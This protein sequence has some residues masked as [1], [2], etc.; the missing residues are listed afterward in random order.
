MCLDKQ[1]PSVKVQPVRTA[2]VTLHTIKHFKYLTLA[3]NIVTRF[4][5]QG[6]F[7]PLCVTRS[8]VSLSGTFQEEEV[9]PLS[10]QVLLQ[11]SYELKIERCGGARGGRRRCGGGGVENRGKWGEERGGKERTRVEIIG[12]NK[13]FKWLKMTKFLIWEQKPARWYF[14][15]YMSWWSQ[16]TPRNNHSQI[17][18]RVKSGLNVS[19]WNKLL[20]PPTQ[21]RSV[22][23]PMIPLRKKL[24][25]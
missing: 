17:N 24:K 16:V 11:Q 3:A 14:C 9:H 1:K 7:D 15:V 4:I 8:Q 25:N 13:M 20:P 5:L 12:N 6:V 2:F 18:P 10:L 23:V 19:L 22:C 21:T